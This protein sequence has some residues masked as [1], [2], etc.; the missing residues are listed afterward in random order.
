[1]RYFN[2]TIPDDLIMR[3]FAEDNSVPYSSKSARKLRDL[4]T[5]QLNPHAIQEVATRTTQL[6]TDMS[7]VIR[8]T[9]QRAD[10]YAT[11]A[12]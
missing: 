10:V 5:H 8:V 11:S 2:I 4:I 1:M 12:F 3:V 9:G 7:E 6:F